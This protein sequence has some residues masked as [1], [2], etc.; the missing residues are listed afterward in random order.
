MFIFQFRPRH[1]TISLLYPWLWHRDSAQFSDLHRT[2]SINSLPPCR[3]PLRGSKAVLKCSW[4]FRTAPGTIITSNNTKIIHK[5]PKLGWPSI[6]Y[7]VI[8]NPV[9]MFATCLAFASPPLLELINTIGFH[10]MGSSSLGKS[11]IATIAG[12]VC[13]GLDHLKTWNTTEAA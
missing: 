11:R 6:P 13:G 7:E 1:H 3:S 12:S 2:A 8:G 5:A 9:V 4:H 10:M